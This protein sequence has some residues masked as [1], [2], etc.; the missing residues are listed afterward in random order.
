MQI[1]FN[2]Q[3]VLITGASTGIGRAAAIQFG[4]CG[5][6]VIVNYNKSENE[7][8]EVVQEIQSAGSQA[9]A[10]QAD[11]ARPEEVKRLFA[12]ATAAF[13]GRID[14]LVNNAGSLLEDRK[15]VV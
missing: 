15:S 12:E 13:G 3:V 11:V 6:N 14:I 2:D 7:A 10:V 5:A 4:K 1:R 8:K 9:L